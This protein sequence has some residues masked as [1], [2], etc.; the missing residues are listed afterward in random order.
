MRKKTVNT[1]LMLLIASVCALTGFNAVIVQSA[2]DPQGDD[3]AK[4]E[5]AP[6][7]AEEA[8]IEAVDEG[9]LDL[10]R[11]LLQ[12]KPALI[13]ARDE[14]G[15]TALHVAVAK[16]KTE[17]VKLLLA[18]KADV[19]ARDQLS[20]TP[21][22]LA[23]S[24]DDDLVLAE[25]LLTAKADPNLADA[26]GNTPLHVTTE[27]DMA[28]LLIAKGAD[29]GARNNEGRT[30][31]HEAVALGAKIVVEALLNNKAAVNA[32]DK[33]G[34]TALHLLLTRTDADRDWTRSIAEILL[35][36]KADVN[37]RNKAGVTVLKMALDQKDTP[38]VDLLRQNG[39]KE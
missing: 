25:L 32:I 20:E 6:A 24:A 37:V 12:E 9:N 39:A 38:L 33:E 19:N 35:A 8:F 16:S 28:D 11:K 2:Q 34:N 17:I 5:A 29:I 3:K 31:L 21:L 36:N 4:P 13:G 22:Y 30:P 7:S 1:L 26:D 18:K 15:A 27:R 23:I 10:V 14:G